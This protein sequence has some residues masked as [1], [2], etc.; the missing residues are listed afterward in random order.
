MHRQGGYT[1][2]P[3]GVAQGWDPTSYQRAAKA[4]IQMGYR[5]IAVGGLVRSRTEDV[6]RTLTAIK[7]VLPFGIQM[8]LFGV[9]RPEYARSFS[10]AGVT[11]FDSASRLRR[12]W[13][14]GRQNYLLDDASFTAVR[15]PEAASLAARRHKAL[16]DAETKEGAGKPK[17]AAELRERW[18]V[19][20][21][22]HEELRRERSEHSPYFARTTGTRRPLTRR[23]PQW[24]HM[25]TWRA[26]GPRGLRATMRGPCVSV[27][28][29][30]ARVPSAARSA[31]R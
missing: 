8:H 25:Q 11:S 26:T 19:Q 4:L 15:V 7:E 5:H 16:Q 14:D 29:N 17:E 10:Q 1:F 20:V 27:R 3:V 24:L 28:G 6:L 30:A 9:N 22:A 18:R 21:G 31:S 2:T 13:M 23:S 12:A